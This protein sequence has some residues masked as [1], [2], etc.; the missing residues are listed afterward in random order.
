M[1]S[2]PQ[3]GGRGRTRHDRHKCESHTQ[4][5]FNSVTGETTILLSTPPK[6]P[7]VCRDKNF[8]VLRLCLVRVTTKFHAAWRTIENFKKSWGRGDARWS[9]SSGRP[10]SWTDWRGR[11]QRWNPFLEVFSVLH[12]RLA[13]GQQDRAVRDGW[14]SVKVSGLPQSLEEVS[15]YQTAE[16]GFSKVSRKREITYFNVRANMLTS[17]S[18]LLLTLVLSRFDHIPK[19]AGLSRSW[20]EYLYGSYHL[21]NTLKQM[22]NNMQHFLF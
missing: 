17:V 11:Q 3:D 14:V 16:K 20:V 4:S 2:V 13:T 8:E 15:N 12:W 18:V 22:I 19:W 7:K 6:P 10:R 5:C 9:R 1:C 21:H